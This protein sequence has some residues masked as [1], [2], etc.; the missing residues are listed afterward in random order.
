MSATLSMDCNNEVI[1]TVAVG[2]T[3]EATV[4]VVGDLLLYN[5]GHDNNHVQDLQM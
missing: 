1:D 3:V 5:N 2:N 4:I